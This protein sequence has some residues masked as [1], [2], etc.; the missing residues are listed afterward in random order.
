IAWRDPNLPEMNTMKWGSDNQFVT[1]MYYRVMYQVTLTSEFI[2]EMSDDKLSS[3]GIT[4]VQ[5]EE[6]RLFR[7]EARFLRA[8]S[9]AHA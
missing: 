1:A 5:A 2:R 7:N 8:L 6:A 9:Y 3:R 4:G